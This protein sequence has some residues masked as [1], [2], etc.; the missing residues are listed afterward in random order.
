ME[1]EIVK[2]EIIKRE[3]NQRIKK[4]HREYIKNFDYTGVQF[5]VAYKDHKKIEWQNLKSS[6]TKGKLIPF[7]FLKRSTKN[8]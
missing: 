3:K 1:R 4:A 6:V 8:K 7:A 2:R 5:P